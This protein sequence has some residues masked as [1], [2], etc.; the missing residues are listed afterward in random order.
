MGHIQPWPKL[1]LRTL[2]EDITNKARLVVISRDAI[3]RRIDGCID[4]VRVIKNLRQ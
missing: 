2:D 4:T 3:I 1:L